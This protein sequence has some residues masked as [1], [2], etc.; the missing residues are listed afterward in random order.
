MPYDEDLAA[1]LRDLL[2]R[3]PG[4]A[5]KRLFGGVGFFLDGNMAVGVWKDSF[6]ARLGPHSDESDDPHARPFAPAGRPLRGWVLVEP[7]GADDDAD[8]ARWVDRAVAF[9]ETL[10]PKSP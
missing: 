3:R 2:G 5:E 8:L 1:R 4:V 7:P 9:V 6:V 10:P